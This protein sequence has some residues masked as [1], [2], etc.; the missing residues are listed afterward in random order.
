MGTT[1]RMA[2]LKFGERTMVRNDPRLKIELRQAILNLERDGEATFLGASPTMESVTNALWHWFAR[3]PVA[4]ADAFLAAEYP[5][6]EAFMRGR[7]AAPETEPEAESG[8]WAGNP[9]PAPKATPR[10]RRKGA[11]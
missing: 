7:P 10:P 3:L 6:L 1:L 4:Q 2:R 11:G 8:E 5:R 9:P